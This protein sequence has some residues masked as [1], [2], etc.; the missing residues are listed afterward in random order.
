MSENM[1][2][3]EF[4]FTK[5][6]I[7]ERCDFCGVCFEQCP[8][9]KLP[10][11]EAQR[12]IRL[13]AESGNSFVLARCTGCMACNT[14]CPTDAN[15]YTLI[16]SRWQERYRAEGLP[17]RA[18]LVLPH[19]EPNLYSIIM[20][21]LPED[22]KS[23]VKQWERNWREPPSD[24]MLYA[25]CNILM[26]PFLMDSA[27]FK[28][29]RIFGALQ[30][31]CGEPLYRMGCWDAAKRA[32]EKLSDEF[33]RMGLKKVL[34]P[35]LAG[36]HLFTHVYKD[37]FDV[38]LDVEVIPIGDWLEERIRAGSIRIAPLGKTAVVHDNCWP[39]ASG[40][41]FFEKTRRLLNLLG[42]TVVE[43]EHTREMA[44]CCGMCAGAAQF[45]LMDVFNA[46]RERLKEFEHVKADMVIDYC[47]GCHWMFSLVAHFLPFTRSKP[48]YNLLEVLQMAAG[49][50]PKRRTDQRTWKIVTSMG[51][52]L[53]R[54]YMKGGR[55][56]LE[57]K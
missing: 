51:P 20:A 36:F 32:A 31:C 49:E 53:L 6:F 29:I 13:L 44:L 26:Q 50:T 46:A 10:L 42:V 8:V 15:P 28:D 24:F 18:G 3:K 38:D 14:L 2:L 9:L 35:C 27:L 37:V 33:R 4:Q 41:L 16:M 12:E 23:L 1:A 39:K 25:G 19:R 56:R 45:S 52:R 40:D 22:E 17:S 21:T 5:G 57:E 47:G 11:Q 43:P 54:E 48:V 34:M 7:R 30:L 55:F